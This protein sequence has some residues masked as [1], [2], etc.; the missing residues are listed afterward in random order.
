[1]TERQELTEFERGLIMGGYPFGHSEREI[2][3]ITS[4]AKSKIHDTIERYCKTGTVTPA[5]RTGRPPILTDRNKRHLE[6]V[7][8]TN[9]RQTIKQIH[10]NFVQ[11]PV[12]VNYRFGRLQ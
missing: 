3:E 11:L 8:R 9:R 4:H 1:M 12:I 2:E 5:P 6:I 10:T 7:V